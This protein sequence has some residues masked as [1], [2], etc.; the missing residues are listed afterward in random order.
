MKTTVKKKS[1]FNA[2]GNKPIK[3]LSWESD[4]LKMIDSNENAVYCKIPGASCVGLGASVT[5]LSPDLNEVNIEAEDEPNDILA[6]H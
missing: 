5:S 3:L 1:N 4:F 6:L 2:T